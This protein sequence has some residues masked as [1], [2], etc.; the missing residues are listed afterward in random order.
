LKRLGYV[1]ETKPLKKI[2]L[3]RKKGE[4]I[5]KCNFD[6]EISL[7]VARN[8]KSLDLV[9]IGS[10]DSDF[11]AVREFALENKKG[12]IA[13]CFERGVAWEIRRGYHIFLEDI[14]G[15]IEEKNKKPRKKR[16]VNN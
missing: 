16:G 1:V 9:M 5:Y 14:K 12:F 11:L 7:D 3:D 6:V 8:T 15:K 4:F 10:G 2:W 13:L